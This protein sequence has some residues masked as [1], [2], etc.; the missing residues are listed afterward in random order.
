MKIVLLGYGMEGEGAYRYFRQK[1]PEATFEV[2]DNAIEPKNALPEGVVFHGGVTDFTNIDADLVVRTPAIPPRGI[3]TRGEVTSVTKEFFEVCPAPIIGV[4]GT[5]G[6]GTTCTLIARMLEGAGK[7]VWLVGN[8]GKPALDIVVAPSVDSQRR[9]TGANSSHPV[10]LAGHLESIP[11][12]VSAQDIVVYELSSFQLWDL[13]K[14]PQTAVVLLIEPDHLNVHKDFDDYVAAKGN[15]THYQTSDDVVVY[16]P[17]NSDSARIANESP[18]QKKRYLTP[19]GAYIEGDTIMIE[20]QKICTVGEVAL[21]GQHNLE[22]VCAAVTAAW[23]YTQDVDAIVQA[24]RSFTGLPHHIEKVRELDGV[25][26]YDDSYSSAFPATIA[27]VKSF[28]RP[29]ILIL[30]GLDRGIDITPLVEQLSQLDNLKHVMAIGEV[31]EKLVPALMDKK[32]WVTDINGSMD[33]IVRTAQ[34]EAVSG[35]VVLLSPG[36]ASFDQYKN[37]VVRGE[38]FQEEVGKL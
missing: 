25:E 11:G 31:R 38:Q 20:G 30:G 4:T 6:K 26:Y 19:E 15:I 13:Q 22:N 27:A 12:A 23:R 33:T 9:S 36:F 10:A 14:S 16:H 24:I 8:I 32:M 28:T 35:D 34:R 21:P 1:F 2:L 5:K 37:F 3:T 29:V 18:A 17:T 7:K